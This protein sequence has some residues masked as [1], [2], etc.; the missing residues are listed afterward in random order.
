[1][2]LTGEYRIPAPRDDVWRALNDPNILKQCIPGCESVEKLSDTEFTAKV[3]LKIGP[4]S[5]KFSGK[6]TL[7]N[8]DPPNGYTITGEGQGGVAGFGKGTADVKL[9]SDG[10]ATVM[11][12]KAAAQVGGKMAQ[13]GARLID[14]TTKKLADEFFGKFA[15]VVSPAAAS[16]PSPE[17]VP[18]AASGAAVTPGKAP[19]AS[20][21]A[22]APESGRIKP[23]VWIP[24]LVIVI[25]AVLWWFSR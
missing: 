2:D 23:T 13:L 15:Q 3:V 17:E 8:L 24:V 7:S 21:S 10:N 6:G 12:Y 1:M 11:H 5:A 9:V 20:P 19:A 25:A 18:E 4:M 22:A 14:S 16:T